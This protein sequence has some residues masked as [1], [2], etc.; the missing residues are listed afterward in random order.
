MPINRREFL[1]TVAGAAA[2]VRLSG[3]TPDASPWNGTV[4]DCHLHIRRDLDA[5]V[6]HM[7]G[8]G[9]SHAVILARDN[10]GDAMHAA[11]A[12]YPGRLGWAASTDIAQPGAE[13]RLTQA[14]K[15]GARGFGELKFHVEAD[16]PE[17]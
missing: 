3:Q 8:C 12:K 4:V 14:V 13:A 16:G 6:V 17:L 1:E 10:S 9:V 5:N 11:Q 7:D 15:D 2:F